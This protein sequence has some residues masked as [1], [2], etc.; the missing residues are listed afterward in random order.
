M[1]RRMEYR[2]STKGDCRREFT[3]DHGLLVIAVPKSLTSSARMECCQVQIRESYSADAACIH[4]YTSTCAMR[5]SSLPTVSEDKVMRVHD[6]SRV[7]DGIF[8]HFHH[9]WIEEIQRALNG[10]LLP[11]WLYAFAIQ[12]GR[13]DL[14]NAEQQVSEFGPDVLAFQAP[15]SKDEMKSSERD[16]IATVEVTRV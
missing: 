6:W 9:S 8:H 3:G 5:G 11:E 2:I 10:G 13:L 7:D 12:P 16:G 15:G 1:K 4:G 14:Q